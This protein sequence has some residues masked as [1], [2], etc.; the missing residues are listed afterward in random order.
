MLNKINLLATSFSASDV[1]FQ[2]EEEIVKI[3]FRRDGELYE[4]YQISHKQYLL[5][6]GEIK[7]FSG[8][9]INIK[10]L[11]QD[12]EYEFEV[13]ERKSSVRVS[14][15]PSKY[16][17]SI[18]LRILDPGKALIKLE[19]LGFSEYNMKLISET[20]KKSKGLILVAGPTG[21]GKTSTL[22][23][24]LNILNQPDK[25][26]ITLEDPIEYRLKNII[27]SEI[28]EQE[29]YTFETGLRSVLRQDP[30]VIMVGEIRDKEAAEIALQASLT[31]H[32]VLSTVHANDAISTIPRLINMGVK[33][34]ILAAGLELIISQRL[35]RRICENC[36][37]PVVIEATVREELDQ[38]VN[39]LNQKGIQVTADQIYGAKGCEKCANT[40]FQGRVAVAEVLVVNDRI[41]SLILAGKSAQE[42]FNFASQEGFINIKEDG[43][44]KVLQGQTTLEEVW[45]TLI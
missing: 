32:L 15:L 42:I 34:F 8:L 24:C 25:K 17:E 31:G 38:V 39:S 16:G 7:R 44:L 33:P 35:L 22:Y 9:K 43:I 27:Q 20:L 21:S 30:D 14:T 40:K 1:H 13:N 2:P 5:L 23:S 45:K 41:R 6:S 37:Y 3:R 29:N 18:V 28:K 19:E 12:G 36:K 11:P 10:N 26:I 4:V